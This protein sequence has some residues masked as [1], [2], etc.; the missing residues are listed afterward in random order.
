MFATNS[1]NPSELFFILATIKCLTGR[2]DV[3]YHRFFCAFCD[4]V[5]GTDLCW[6]E[7]GGPRRLDAGERGQCG[8]AFQCRFRQIVMFGPRSSWSSLE[9]FYFTLLPSRYRDQFLKIM[10]GPDTFVKFCRAGFYRH[11]LIQPMFHHWGW[12]SYPKFAR[13]TG[14]CNQFLWWRII[15]RLIWI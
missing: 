2:C 15:V 6:W 4:H 3:I 12:C 8:A 9:S 11:R 1:H 5:T 10:G 14:K 13:R 7:S